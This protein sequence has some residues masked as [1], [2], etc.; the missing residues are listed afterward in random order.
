M[1]AIRFQGFTARY[2]IK[3]LE[4]PEDGEMNNG[5][6]R[7]GAARLGTAGP[8][9]ARQNLNQGGGHVRNHYKESDVERYQADYIRQVSREQQDGTPSGAKDVSKQTES[10]MLA[11]AQHPEFFM[12]RKHEKRG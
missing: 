2:C 1:E 9:M 10:I 11:C 4:I 5:P 8:G 12:C 3:I 6:A 7:R